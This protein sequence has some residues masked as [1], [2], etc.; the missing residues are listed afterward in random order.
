[1]RASITV[2]RIYISL[3]MA[4]ALSLCPAPSSSAPTMQWAGDQTVTGGVNVG[5]ATDAGPAQVKVQSSSVSPNVA[6]RSISPGTGG[7]V[8]KYAGTATAPYGA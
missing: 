1:M 4:A 7:S 6:W 8:G 2:S 3:L 5:E